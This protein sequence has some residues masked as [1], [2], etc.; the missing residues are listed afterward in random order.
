MEEK[1]RVCTTIAVCNV[2]GGTGKTVTAVNLSIGLARHGKRVLLVD[3]NGSSGASTLLI[4]APTANVPI[5]A[6][7]QQMVIQRTQGVYLCKEE[8]SLEKAILRHKE[9][10]DI[11]QSGS[12][13][14]QLFLAYDPDYATVLWEVLRPARAEYDCIILDCPPADTFVID[15]ALTAADQVL[16]PVRMNGRAD[17]QIHNTM[18]KILN[19]K[20]KYNEELEILG[21]LPTQKTAGLRV[22]VNE[23]KEL[24]RIY[25]QSMVIFPIPVPHSDCVELAN[26]AGL[27]L[28]ETA[29]FD[30]ATIAYEMLVCNVLKVCS[31]Q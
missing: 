1:E 25:G 23:E 17:R 12:D 26:C 15:N 11:I 13:S 6:L 22:S 31:S 30:G 7:M 8:I 20:N 16:I 19:V 21:V 10:I 24:Q 18:R 28:F 9:G 5:S 14:A 27:S 4:H 29:P 3:L 2:G